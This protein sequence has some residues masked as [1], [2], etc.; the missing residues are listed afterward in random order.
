MSVVGYVYP[1]DFDGDPEAAARAAALGLDR[2]AIAATYHASRTVSPL[3]PT[4]RVREVPTS[5]A[6]VA[7][8][9]EVWRG[10][11]LVPKAPSWPGGANEF[12]AAAEVASRAG[13]EVAAWVVVSH[14]DELGAA[15]PDLVVRNAFGEPYSYGLCPRSPEV[16]EYAVTL[17]REVVATTNVA[18]LVLEACGP[19]GLSHGGVHD[20]VEFA[21]YD[22]VAD[23]LMSICFCATC[24]RDLDAGGLGADELAR[25]IRHGVDERPG[26]LELILGE[27]RAR[28]LR[29]FRAETAA[30]LQRAVLDAVAETR[31]GVAVTLHGSAIPGATGSFPEVGRDV[32]GRLDAVVA[33]AWDERMAR[34]EIEGLVALGEAATPVGAYLRL[35]RDE[36]SPET[37]VA[38]YRDAGVTQ[39]HLYHLGL[40]TREDLERAARVVAAASTGGPS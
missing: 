38:T 20:K 11:R 32:L 13:L 3:H 12:A 14:H 26:S 27:E 31:P 36:T 40:A 21:A 8:R 23:D 2:V 19:M 15:N 5:A 18:S 29:A 28:A 10:R 7:L 4:R 35:D 25:A 37:L 22:A 30:S 9:P 39:W 6:Y 34:A 1:W 16:L 24:A 33:N 17:V